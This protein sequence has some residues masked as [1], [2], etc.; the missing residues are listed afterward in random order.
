MAWSELI[1]VKSGVVILAVAA[2][3]A[4]AQEPVAEVVVTANR[5]SQPLDDVGASIDSI[6]GS[7]LRARGVVSTSDLQKLVPGFTASDTGVNIPVYS[8]RGVGLN[9]PSLAANSTIVISVDE[10]PLP[11]TAMAQGEI[12]DVERVEVLK[13][14]QGT[15]YGQNAT[16]GAINYIANKPGDTLAMGWDVGFG[17]FSTVTGE[18]FLGGPLGKTLKARLAVGGTHGEPWQQNFTRE[19]QLG[20]VARSSARL[21][22]SWQPIEKLDVDLNLNGWV[23][24]SDTQATQ[25]VA[26]RPQV[27]ANVPRVPDVFSSPLTPADARAANWNPAR[28]YSRSDDFRQFSVKATYALGER[29][30]L[31]S[32]TAWSD[33]ESGGFNDRDG[34]VPADFE[35]GTE[36]HIESLYQEVRLSHETDALAWSMGG[37]FRK[38]RA[39]DFQATDVSRG[40]NTFVAGLKLNRVDIYTDQHVKTYAVFADG[41]LRLSSRWAL[42][43]GIRY[44]RDTRDFSG[45]TCDVGDGETS[46]VYT[47]LSNTFRT[48]F[49]LPQ[50]PALAPNECVTLSAGTFTP[51]VVNDRLVEDNVAFRGQVNLKPTDRSLLYASFSRGFKAGSFP[52]L[53]T[54]F[55]PG[56]SP[57]TQERVDALEAGF[58]TTLFERRARLQGAAF[59]YDYHDKQLRGRIL[60]PVIGN[61]SRLV[62]VPRSVIRG[63]ELDLTTSLRP[64]LTLQMA[65]AHLDTE[66]KEFV[67]VNL[68]GQTE[69][70]AG[71]TLPYSPPW[72]A[73]A[74]GQYEWRVFGGMKAFVGAD[75]AYR[76]RTSG[77][78]GRDRPVDI[79]AWATLDL[80]AGLRFKDDRWQIQ[81]WGN[82]VTDADYL[83]SA[84]R[85]GDTVNAYAARPA[86]YGISLGFRN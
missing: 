46:A 53:A 57:A 43:A 29:A 74:G 6:D 4:V 54:V 2:S 18:F 5:R 66:V 47:V 15:L 28:D 84:M 30:R 12:L 59:H 50:L 73:N 17:R 61:L 62:N 27:V 19:D 8:L 86:T 23:D 9:E 64:G 82:N 58:N 24:R 79:G 71:Q 7:S 49:G 39:Y 78:I 48:Q 36:G 25:I 60:D 63:F 35:F 44:T 14:P 80:R 67:G 3:S 32:I 33:F 37:N 72:S 85:N 81:V 75:Y 45:S 52:T 13:G 69:D 31:T 77:F 16:G 34:M 55:S 21:L 40:T 76:S 42:V 11:Y 10:V 20:R 26:F 68:F 83:T 22:A 51:G 65:I 56:Y 1:V 41:E 38:D 70:F